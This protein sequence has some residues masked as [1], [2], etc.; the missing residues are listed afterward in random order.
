MISEKLKTRRQEKLD[1]RAGVRLVHTPQRAQMRLMCRR[2][3]KD[4]DGPNPRV[5]SAFE[6]VL[7]NRLEGIEGGSL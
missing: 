4:L 7:L 6:V 3:L 1:M 2:V 5:L